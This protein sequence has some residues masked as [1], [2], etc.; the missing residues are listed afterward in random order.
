MDEKLSVFRTRVNGS[1]LGQFVGKSVSLIGTVIKTNPGGK[2]FDV[3]T[4]ERQVVTVNMERPLDEPV[5]GLV[6]IH[7]TVQGKG[8]IL[9]SNYIPFPPE[10]SENFDTGLENQA[11]L[12]MHNV[13]NP[14]R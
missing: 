1:L 4:G 9:C 8:Q 7:G 6:E 2:S 11:V 10:M 14:W 3:Q 12:L 5:S 13:Q